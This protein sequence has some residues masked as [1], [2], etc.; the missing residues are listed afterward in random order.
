MFAVVLASYYGDIYTTH[1]DAVTCAKKCREL[2][3]LGMSYK[4]FDYNGKEYV[5]EGN[6]CIIFAKN[7]ENYPLTAQEFK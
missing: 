2:N 1:K 4:I 5:L 6:Y 3:Q 7:E